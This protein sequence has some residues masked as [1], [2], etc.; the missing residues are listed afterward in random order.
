V[1]GEPPPGHNQDD[2]AGRVAADV[3][4]HRADGQGGEQHREVLDRLDSGVRVVDPGD[5]PLQPMSVNCRR[6]NLVL[7]EGALETCPDG[8]V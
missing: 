1:V 6:P 8:A 5:S 2:G 4:A 7:L 3:V